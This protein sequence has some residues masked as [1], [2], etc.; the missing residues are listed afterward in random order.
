MSDFPQDKGRDFC[1]QH[2]YACQTQLVVDLAALEYETRGDLADEFSLSQNCINYNEPVGFEEWRATECIAWL[3]ANGVNEDEWPD[4]WATWNEMEESER[5]EFDND[6]DT[7]SEDDPW[8]EC[9]R[10]HWEEPE[11]YEWYMVSDWF[12]HQLEM[13]GEIILKNAYGSWWG[14]QCG[15]QA[16][17]MD[18]YLWPIFEKWFKED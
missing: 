15:G 10:D 18:N 8:R 6:I 13:I 4:V 7:F 11:I 5:E 9:V 3:R 14:R 12:E 16:I 17:Y 1:N 2:V